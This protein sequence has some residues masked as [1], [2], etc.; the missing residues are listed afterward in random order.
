M[1]LVVV[2]MMVLMVVVLIIVVIIVV[3]DGTLDP[4]DPA[5]RTGNLVEVEHTGAYN[6]VQVYVAPVAF[7]NA[8]GWLQGLDNLPDKLQV[9]FAYLGLFVQQHYVAELDLL[10]EQVLYVVLIQTLSGETGTVLELIPHPEGV[11]D[12]A[13]AVQDGNA[14]LAEFRTHAWDGAYCLCDRSRFANAAGFYD[15]V[16]EALHKGDLAQLVHEVHLQRAA[17]AAVLECDE[18]V[19][20]LADNSSLLN[21]L[22]VNVDLTYVIDYHCET[23]SFAIVEDTVEQSSLAASKIARQQQNR[24]FIELHIY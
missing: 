24:Y 1:M 20:L 3:L 17:D 8:R 12:C 9:G 5:R 23:Y 13:D 19:V 10:Y 22:R 7:D 2:L 18:T 21:E 4:F 6:A 16:V 11:H 15:Y 14:S